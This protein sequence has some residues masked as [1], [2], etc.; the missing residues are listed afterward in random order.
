MIKTEL[1]KQKILELGKVVGNDT[2]R[3]DMFLNHRIDADL[4]TKLGGEFY[5]IFSSSP[6]NKIVTVEASG[7]AVAFAAAQRF[8]V[9]VVF[10]KK[11]LNKNVGDDVYKARVYSFTKQSEV[12][13]GVAKDY[14]DENDRV[15]IIDDFLASG[16]AAKGLID[17]INQAGARL[18]GVG[19]VIEKA[20]QS[21]GD[22]LRALGYRVESLAVIKSIDGGKIVFG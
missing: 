10:A 22:E 19:V 9:P 15:L 8:S 16:S 2:V 14:L 12:I 18:E 13:I 3:V 21:G 4:V 5:R 17:I 7:V 20:F 1:L 6:I 11:G